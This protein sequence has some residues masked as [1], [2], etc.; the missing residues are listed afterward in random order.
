[1]FGAKLRL[2]QGADIGVAEK[3][4]H[5]GAKVS[6]ARALIAFG[7]L[8]HE[9]RHDLVEQRVVVVESLER[10]E[11]ADKRPRLARLDARREQE[12]Q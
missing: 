9:F 5:I 12:K 6:Q 1:M 8:G 7:P 11:R 10:D 2:L 4:V 3:S